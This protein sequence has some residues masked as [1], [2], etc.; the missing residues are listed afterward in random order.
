MN[1]VIVFTYKATDQSGQ[2]VSG[3]VE[4]PNK[5]EALQKIETLRQLGFQNITIEHA[6]IVD[7]KPG[8]SEEVA[9]QSQVKGGMPVAATV[10]HV[11]A[12]LWTLICIFGFFSGVVAVSS[13]GKPTSP[14]AI[15]SECK[16]TWGDDYAMLE[17]CIKAKEE[18]AKNPQ[19]QT[20]GTA[21]GIA[22]TVG[23]F[24]WM[25]LWFFPVV[26]LEIIAIAITVGSKKK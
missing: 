16:K 7:Q 8:E 12:V 4:A 22:I 23:F 11:L 21:E 26:G 20:G 6:D 2:P 10:C 19:K 18:A 25:M 13:K 15:M 3:K 24:F 17:T 9:A 5:E 14:E 1:T